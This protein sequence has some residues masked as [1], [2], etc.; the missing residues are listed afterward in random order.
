MARIVIVIDVDLPP[1]LH[2]PHEVADGLLDQRLPTFVPETPFMN[3][4]GVSG[5]F[6][7]AEWES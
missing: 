7:S 4:R 6:I 5:A 2:D 3:D 1:T